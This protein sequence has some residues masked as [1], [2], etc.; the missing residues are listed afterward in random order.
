MT[1]LAAAKARKYQLAE[2][3]DIPAVATDIIYEGAAVGDSSGTARPLV[4]GDAFL[5]FCDRTADNSAGAAGAINVRC[6]QR[7][8]IEVPVTGA[9]GTDDIGAAV[10]AADDDTFTLTAGSNTA[11]GKVDSYV[12]GTTCVVYFEA[13]AV[14]SI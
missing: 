5:G 3:V 6:K 14:R 1:T 8:K 2:F 11:I 13:L 12:T 4:A 10:Y 9:T 7:G